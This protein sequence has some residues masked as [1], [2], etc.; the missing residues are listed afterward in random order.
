MFDFH[1]LQ[2]HLLKTEINLCKI[3][4]VQKPHYAEALLLLAKGIA[5]RYASMVHLNKNTQ[6]GKAETLHLDKV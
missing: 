1:C 4:I 2:V 3:I 5:Q 6:H